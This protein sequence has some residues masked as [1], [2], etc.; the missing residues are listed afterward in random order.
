[1]QTSDLPFTVV[2]D[3]A[4]TGWTYSVYLQDEWKSYADT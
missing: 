2:D 1:M 3:T 4:K